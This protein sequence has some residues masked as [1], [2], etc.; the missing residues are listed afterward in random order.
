MSRASVL[1]RGRR[2]ALAGM[3]DACAITRTTGE[4]VDAD[5]VTTPT[6]ATI[7]AGQCRVQLRT[8]TGAGHGRDVGEAYVIIQNLE[9]QIPIT[10]AA[11]L[12]GD[13]V[14]ITAAAS[15]PLLVGRVY[16]IRDVVAKS[17]LTARRAT[18]LEITS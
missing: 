11:V 9:L 17:E 1:A 3:T 6:T 18:M 8:A 13:T 16:A 12:E 14:T 4:S 10:A 5:G 2:A 7:Y 15:D